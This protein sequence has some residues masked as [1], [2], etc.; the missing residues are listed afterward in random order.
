MVSL[1]KILD[2]ILEQGRFLLLSKL[3]QETILR[4]RK[5]ESADL[6]VTEQRLFREE[7]LLLNHVSL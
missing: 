6:L 1:G 3:D 7:K 2:I 5:V 4:F